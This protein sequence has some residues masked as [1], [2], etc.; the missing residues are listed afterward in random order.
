MPTASEILSGLSHLANTYA[1]FALF[2]HVVLWA[3]IVR[4]LWAGGPSNRFMALFGVSILLSVSAL[5]WISGNPFNGSVFLLFAV[6]LSAFGFQV[7]TKPVSR[8]TGWV[9]ITGT[10]LVVFGLVYPHFLETDSFL[11]YLYQAPVGLIPCPTLSV[12]TGFALIF[13]GYESR[14]WSLSLAVIGLFYGVFGVFKLGVTMDTV[15][16]AGALA[17]SVGALARYDH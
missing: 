7:D 10:L 14:K 1:G 11:P 4:L 9:F 15:L 13:K 8:S 2:W 16:L 6:L 3:L 12:V 5:A 17:L